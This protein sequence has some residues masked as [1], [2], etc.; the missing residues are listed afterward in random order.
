VP[1]NVFSFGETYI[2]SNVI[3]WELPGVEVQPVVR[4]LD[5]IPIN[6][7]LLEDAIAVAKAVT[8][9]R[10]VQTGKAVEEAG[11]ET[12]KTTITQG[13]IVF[14]LDDVFDAEA[15]FGKALCRSP[16]SGMFLVMW[17]VCR[18]P[19]LPLARALVPKFNMAL[20]S[21]RPMR[22]SRLK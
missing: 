8:P 3:A 6:D 21:V 18:R 5:L 19:F 12:A 15:K 2:N 11:S 9:S 13:G 14:L 20:S 7:F 22:N 10:V 16:V 17:M 4:H 1:G